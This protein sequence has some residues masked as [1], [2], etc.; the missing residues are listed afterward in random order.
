MTQR[1]LSAAALTVWAKS[2]RDAGNP[3][4]IVGWLPL[5]QHLD[6]S[7]A[8]AGRLWDEWVTGAVK[9]VIARAFD[10]DEKSARSLYV[11][12]ASV[13]DL[14]K[15]SPAFSCQ[16]DALAQAMVSTGL[17]ISPKLNGSDERR[18]AR[19]EL[20]SY[21]V[22]S[23]WLN[24]TH[25]FSLDLAIQF[26]SILAAHHGLPPSSPQLGEARKHRQSLFGVGSWDVVR[27][28]FLSRS[29]AAVPPGS[30]DRW[31]GHPL[32]L[33]TQVLLSGLVIVAD[34]IASNEKYFPYVPL[35][36]QPSTSTAARADA[37]WRALE[38]PLPWEPRLPDHN[39]E[40]L[41]ATRFSLPAGATVRPVQRELARIARELPE[42]RLIIVEAEMGVGKTEAALAAAEILAA[43]FRLGG[44]FVG[45]PTQATADGLFTRVLDWAQ[46]LDLSTPNN[47]FLAR[48]K[49]S[50]NEEYAALATAAYFRSIGEDHR[51]RSQSQNRDDAVIAHNWFSDP[52][53]GPL[54]N[55]VVGTIDQGLFTG[56]RSRHLMLRHLALAGKVVIVDEAHAHSDFMNVYAERML[57]WL[58][59]YDV[60]VIILSATLPSERRKSLVAAYDQ[61]RLASSRG[62]RMDRKAQAE[63]AARHDVLDGDIGYPLIT[64]SGGRQSPTTVVPDSSGVSREVELERIDDSDESLVALLNDALE[65]GGCAAVIRNT[66]S[67]VQRIA[68]VLRDAFPGVPVTVAHS[69]FLALDRAAK[70]AALLRDFGKPAPE[71]Q[72][73][74]RHIV[75]ASQ[76]AEQSLDIDF[77]L[78]VT[79]LAPID[80]LLQR[81]GRL[82]RHERGTAQSARPLA[83]RSARLVV[84]G[85]D[86]EAIPPQPLRDYRSIYPLYLLYRTLAVLDGRTSITLPGDI[87][88]LVQTVYGESSVGPD[89]W[90]ESIATAKAKYDAEVREKRHN[91]EGFLLGQV[92]AREDASL[93]GWVSAHAGDPDDRRGRASVRDGDE[94]I[95][96]IVL[97]RSD[98]GIT[99]QTPEWLE[100]GARQLPLNEP[101]DGA[102]VRTILG[103][104]LRL[105]PAL[106]APWAIEA[107]ITALEHEFLALDLASWHSS[108]ALRG[109]LVLVL[110]ADGNGS[111]GGHRLHYDNDTGLEIVK[112]D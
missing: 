6:D 69:R 32:P 110:D 44:I 68:R 83:V 109:E 37:A 18:L 80:L 97:Q 16:V 82:H 61:G 7:A 3:V 54:A 17:E 93:I 22:V 87:P 26:A 107:T 112:D 2:Q 56:L 72:R 20:V 11:W 10:G 9:R 46:Q 35:G 95:E 15:I 63:F 99:L 77:D 65:D 53:R 71:R 60:P 73:P 100:G 14:G 78:M 38:L 81:A 106:S 101:P 24:E 89:S 70:D 50:L 102:L 45:L 1:P 59:A 21:V 57:H 25:G 52:K 49:A 64:V 76:V 75:V 103:C 12:L 55:L 5:W 96:V 4:D 41:F 105:P 92:S 66:I 23:D 111:V 79:D 33:Y 13:H 85:V 104:A 27:A 88:S 67:R 90:A 94:T 98:D 28:E 108:P 74:A 48:G 40:R 31:R 86:W 84:T 30:F 39:V 8:V 34:W 47:V 29:T 51:S 62:P 42:P 43:R 36:E 19:H 91:A 58:A